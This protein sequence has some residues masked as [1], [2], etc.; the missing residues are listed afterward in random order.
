MTHPGTEIGNIAIQ[1]P[2]DIA[3]Q[4]RTPQP[5]AQGVD[6]R[7]P[8]GADLTG[9][10]DGGQ[11]AVAGEV[12]TPIEDVGQAD[13]RGGRAPL[14][15][16]QWPHTQ[17]HDATGARMGVSGRR[18][19]RAPGQHQASVRIAVHETTYRVPDRGVFLPFVDADAVRRAEPGGGVEPEQ[20]A[21]LG[22]V[23][24][25][26][27]VDVPG[28]RL[29]LAHGLGAVDRQRPQPGEDLLDL[30]VE[31]A[32]EVV[33]IAPAVLLTTVGAISLWKHGHTPIDRFAGFL[34]VVSPIRRAGREGWPGGSG[35]PGRAGGNG[36]PP[37]ARAANDAG[38]TPS[39]RWPD[40]RR[41]RRHWRR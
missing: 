26:D 17:G 40:R 27:S 36:A 30:R 12:R 6:T 19:S 22:G 5:G 8:G 41:E 7:E 29:R 21:D 14:G 32:R 9:V 35:Q 1:D 18:R 25:E 31:I 4:G 3:L 23:E 2:L 13:R 34:P 16:G 24:L 20:L 37:P 15:Q 33:A 38:L 11:A 39:G 10:V 28:S